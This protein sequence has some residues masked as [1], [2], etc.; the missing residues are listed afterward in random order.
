MK[1]TAAELS[2]TLIFLHHFNV[3]IKVRQR[4]ILS[5]TYLLTSY[6]LGAEHNNGSADPRAE[7]L[8]FILLMMLANSHTW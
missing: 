4:C 6:G 3:K 2:T 7:N 5:Q 8:D 1:I